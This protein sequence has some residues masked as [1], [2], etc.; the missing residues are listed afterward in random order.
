V[1]G[2]KPKLKVIEGGAAI[3][4]CLSPPMWLA[5][6]SKREWRRIAPWLHKAAGRV[7]ASWRRSKAIAW[8]WAR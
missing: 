8:Q 3:D 1:K 2:R 4:R 5:L 7:L 6:H